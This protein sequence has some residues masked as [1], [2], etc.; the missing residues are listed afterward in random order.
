MGRITLNGER[1]IIQPEDYPS[2]LELVAAVEKEHIDNGW[3]VVRVAVDGKEITKFTE[4]DESLIPYSPG[5]DVDIEARSPTCILLDTFQGFI[6]HLEKLI[7]GVETVAELFREQRTNEANHLYLDV[8]EGL[9]L[10]FEILQEARVPAEL[11]VTKITSDGLGLKELTDRMNEVL[12]DLVKA[13]AE[14][15]HPR[16]GDLLAADLRDL[17]VLW[18]EGLGTLRERLLTLQ[19][20][21]EK[22]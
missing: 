15:D 19:Q 5:Q 3:I 4:E 1:V 14:S 17:L 12:Q 6:D 13:Q 21:E 18:K 7:P 10:L 8:V 11:E 20:D 2:L 16:L 9:K 22:A